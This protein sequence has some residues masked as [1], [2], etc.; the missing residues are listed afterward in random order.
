LALSCSCLI[1]SAACR[2]EERRFSEPDV[3]SRV[4][5]RPSAGVRQATLAR[6]ANNAWAIGEGQRLYSQ[7]NCIG[8]HAHGGGGMAPPLMDAHWRYGSGLEE[9]ERSIREG[10]PNGMPAFA[11]RL[12]LPQTWQLVA[13]VR[14]LSGLAPSSAA[15]TRDDHLSLAPPPSR[16]KA[17][18]PDAEAR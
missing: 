17:Q 3:L 4:E 1:L 16:T 7:M 8:C 18:R 10:R 11:A 12:S 15:P 9:I 6:Y 13:Y 5:A 2:R 14:S